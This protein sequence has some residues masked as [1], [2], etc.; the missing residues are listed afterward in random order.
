MSCQRGASLQARERDVP[1]NRIVRESTLWSL[2]QQ[3]PINMTQLAEIEDMHPRI[4]RKEGA[5]LLGLIMQAKQL[6]EEDWPAALPEP[7]PIEAA[8]I[9]KRLR[10]VGLQFGQQLDIA[11][12]LMLRKK[13]LEELLRTGYPDGPY[14]LPDSLQGWR[15]EMMGDALLEQLEDVQ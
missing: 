7:L 3:Q 5:T 14:R 4:L 15:R 6:T 2:A 12:E 11:P 13:T 10:K 8:K 9:L 1:R